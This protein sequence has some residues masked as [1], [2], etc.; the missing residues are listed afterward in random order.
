[1]TNQA[2]HPSCHIKHRS[3]KNNIFCSW[4]SL[5][6]K[7]LM[8]DAI[9]VLLLF[10]TFQSFRPCESSLYEQL[11]L[12]CKWIS[13]RLAGALTST[14]GSIHFHTEMS[15]AHKKAIERLIVWIYWTCKSTRSNGIPVSHHRRNA[16]GY[17]LQM[18]F[19]LWAKHVANTSPTISCNFKTIYMF[20]IYCKQAIKTILCMFCRTKCLFAQIVKPC[21][22]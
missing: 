4:T 18:V 6:L 2:G 16:L 7:K 20:Y 1:M 10:Q 11:S 15:I 14:R 17:A 19:V 5:Q 9:T 21:S 3:Y 8:Q 12:H 13:L 22:S